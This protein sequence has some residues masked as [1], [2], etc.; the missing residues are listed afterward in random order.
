MM[1]RALN[2]SAPVRRGLVLAAV[3]SAAESVSL[4]WTLPVIGPTVSGFIWAGGI[5]ASIW[6]ASTALLVVACGRRFLWLLV[7]APAALLW[8]VAFCLLIWSCSHAGDCL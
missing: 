4:R 5:L 8:P 6:A 1:L 3:V 7:L 2:V